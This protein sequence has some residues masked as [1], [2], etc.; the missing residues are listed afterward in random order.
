[1]LL[2]QGG[3]F[4]GWGLYLVKGK[5]VFTWNLLGLKHVRWE[6]PGELAPGKHTLIFDF[7][8]DGLGAGTLAFNS[9]SGIARGGLGVFK[10]DGKEVSSQ[11]FERTMGR[12]IR[13]RIRY[14]YR[15]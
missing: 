7:K 10:I 13:R 2:T 5:P 4:G 11:K 15:S 9:I 1:M 3:R 6:G 12:D 8:Y 14:R